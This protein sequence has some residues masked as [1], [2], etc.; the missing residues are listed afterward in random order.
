MSCTEIYYKS[1][2]TPFMF[3]G[4]GAARAHTGDNVCISCHV[5]LVSRL[6]VSAPDFPILAKGSWVPG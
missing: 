5:S 1:V 4:Q 2:K 3:V 6:K